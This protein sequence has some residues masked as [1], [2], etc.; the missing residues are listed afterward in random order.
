MSKKKCATVSLQASE[1]A[2][3]NEYHGSSSVM[4]I[5]RLSRQ[6]TRMGPPAR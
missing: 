6:P 3:N 4:T 5:T 1:V 2:L